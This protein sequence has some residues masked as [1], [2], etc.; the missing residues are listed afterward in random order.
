[1]YKRIEKDN[2]IFESPEFKKDEYK[3]NIVSK[4]LSGDEVFI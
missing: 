1:M 4:I 3:F 2:K